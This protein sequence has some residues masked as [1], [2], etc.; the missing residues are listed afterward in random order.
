MLKRN[1]KKLSKLTQFPLLALLVA[2]VIFILPARFLA[3]TEVEITYTGNEGFMIEAEGKKILIDAFHRLGNIKN[4]ELLQSGRP[5]FDDV[6]LIL[7]T[8]TDDDHFDLPM[9]ADYLVSH[10]RTHFV[11]TKQAT[12]AFAKYFK[13]HEKIGARLHG[14]APEEGVRIPF[15][16]AGID[17]TMILLHHGRSRQVKVI[18]LGFLFAIGG[19]KFFHMGDSEIV[20]SEIDIYDLDEEKIDVA[21]V[22]YWYFTNEKYKPALHKGIGAK[23]VVPMHLMLMDGGDQ[24]KERILASVSDEFPEA[25]LFSDEMEKRVI[26]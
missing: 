14:F 3:A 26:R 17:I 18:N 11:S 13:D 23:R 7:A 4:Q 5:P 12:V 20:L 6:D 9:V 16:H 1:D 25:I 19:K 24:E 21:F 22:P 10:P 2:Y 8:H 15:S